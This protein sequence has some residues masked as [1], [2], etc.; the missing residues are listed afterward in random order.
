MFGYNKSF[1]PT[2]R[3]LI[4][5]MLEVIDFKEVQSVLEPSAGKG[6]IVDVIIE[7]FKAAKYYNRDNNWDIDCIEID[8]NLRHILTGKGY[9]VVHDDFLTYN[10]YKKYDLIVMN[11]PFID[12]D[13]HLLK[14]LE[15][16]KSGGQVICLLN[17]ETIDNAYSNSRKDLLRKLEEY[18][19]DIE[20]VYNAFVDAERKTEVQVALIAVNI[21]KPE[22]NSVIINHLKQEE[23]FK[24]NSAYNSN[25]NL[26]NADF[27]K[28]IVEQYNFEVKAGLKLIK[29]YEALQPLMLN[30]FDTNG[31][32]KPILKLELESYLNTYSNSNMANSYIEN[33]RIKYWKALFTSQE[34]MGLFTS[35]LRQRY[36]D[37]INELRNYDFSLYNI[38]TI[39]IELNKELIRGVEDTILNLFDEFSHK[40]YWY[41]ETSK[42]IHYYNGWKTNKSWKINDKKVIIPLNAYDRWNSKFSPEW[43]AKEKLADIEKVFSYLDNGT[44]EHIDLLKTLNLAGKE[45]KTKKIELK[46]FYVTFYKKGTC[47]IEWKNRELV[48]KFNV[49]GSQRKGWLPPTYGKVQY[50]DMTPEEKTIIDDFE[51]QESYNNVMHNSDYYIAE[52]SQLLM[53]A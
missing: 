19:A 31:Y 10:S 24:Q 53:L 13:K 28:G 47:H 48:H 25:A 27:I 23:K 52:S 20:Y 46:Y 30:T 18:H 29:E 41:D 15:M 21:D 12:G 32:P 50:K 38:Y 5:K 37:K 17:A 9:R 42:N 40:H 34:F 36:M 2:P 4:E 8:Q 35:N 51:G 33:M 11:P 16:Q 22:H 3:H 44:T 1:Y 39:R 7:K 6:D 49:F 26:I 14:A 43:E 45:G